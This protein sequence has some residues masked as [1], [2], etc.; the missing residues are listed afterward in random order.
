MWRETN[1]GGVYMSPF[2]V[3][4]A[5]AALIWLPVRGLI[6]ATRL[7]RWVVNPPLVQAALY[8]VILGALVAVL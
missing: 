5:A 8:V 6:R 2:L 4:I 7:D 1:I 3:Y